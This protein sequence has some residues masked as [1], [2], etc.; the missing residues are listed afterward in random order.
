MINN[1][2]NGQTSTAD[3]YQCI[4]I[5]TAADGSVNPSWNYDWGNEDDL[6]EGFSNGK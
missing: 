1:A 4:N 5:A 3:W 2:W 6:K